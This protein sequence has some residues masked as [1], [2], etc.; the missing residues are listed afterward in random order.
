M[1]D[2][3]QETTVIILQPGDATVPYTFTFKACTTAIANDGSIPYGT[4]ISSVVVVVFDE[5]GTDVTAQI[6]ASESNTALVET[7]NLKYPA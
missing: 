3:F 6:V 5:S 1:A 7:I 4:T 2:S